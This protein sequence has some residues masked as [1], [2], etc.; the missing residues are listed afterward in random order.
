MTKI[1]F[2]PLVQQNT[3]LQLFLRIVSKLRISSTRWR[4]TQHHRRRIN[5]WRG[6]VPDGRRAWSPMRDFA[7]GEWFVTDAR[8]AYRLDSC[9]YCCKWPVVYLLLANQFNFVSPWTTTDEAVLETWQRTE[10]SRPRRRVRHIREFARVVLSEHVVHGWQLFLGASR[11]WAV[12]CHSCYDRHNVH[13]A[14]LR[15]AAGEDRGCVHPAVGGRYRRVQALGFNADPT[16]VVTD[17][18]MAAMHAVMAMFGQQVHVQ[19]CF[20]HLCQS[21]WRYV[22]DLGLTAMYN[23]EDVA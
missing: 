1:D 20:F 17:F 13:F 9:T 15:L 4:P 14:R 8:G 11:V 3:I 12:V 19:G 2:R 6:L 10:R 23:T 21:T 7:G 18:E 16:T 22:Q 5:Y